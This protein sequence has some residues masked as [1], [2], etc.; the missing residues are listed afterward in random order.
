M[1]SRDSIKHLTPL[2]ASGMAP[3]PGSQN[4]RSR[5]RAKVA[6]TSTTQVSSVGGSA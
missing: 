6:V 2:V 1:E 3:P 4:P 5:M